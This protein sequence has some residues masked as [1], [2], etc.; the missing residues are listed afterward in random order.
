METAYENLSLNPRAE[1]VS[2]R[3]PAWAGLSFSQGRME[4]TKETCNS[5]LFRQGAMAS[6]KKI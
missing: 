6:H 4:I 2:R 5:C 3:K 1:R